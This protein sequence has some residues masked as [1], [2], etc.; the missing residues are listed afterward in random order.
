M[1]SSGGGGGGSV[2]LDTIS[3][4]SAT[5]HNMSASTL[6]VNFVDADRVT[7]GQ[8]IANKLSGSLTTLSNGSDY[9]IA[10]SNITLSTSSLGAIT[11]SSTGGGG[12]DGTIGA[13][14][15]GTYADGLFT[16]FT[17]TTPI[18]TPIDRFNEVLKILAP[19]PAPDLASIDEN[20]TDGVTAKLSFGSSKT[21]ADYSS[22]AT[23][24][25]FSAVDING[26][27]EV[28][29][30]GRNLRIGVYDGTQDITGRLNDNIAA[31]ITN[32]YYA[33]AS[34]AFGNAETGTLKLEINGNIV[35]SIGSV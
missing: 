16:D 26:T 18:G 4:S 13:A 10:G 31:S 1:T 29:N 2:N 12:G 7:T 9:L 27:Y 17:S 19:S 28:S 32:G 23:A 35:H 24:A 3:G 20:I 30:S 14:E 11:I 8:V 21:I 33:Y 34:G 5:Y 6:T 25:G 15:D 22:S